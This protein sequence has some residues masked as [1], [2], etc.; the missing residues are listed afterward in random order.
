M[1]Q[2]WPQDCKL[3]CERFSEFVTLGWYWPTSLDYGILLRVYYPQLL[4]SRPNR[5]MGLYWRLE[6][7]GYHKYSF[8][9]LNILSE[10]LLNF[11]C[12]LLREF[13]LSFK[14][15]SDPDF[16]RCTLWTLPPVSTSPG[17]WSSPCSKK[18]PLPRL[19]LA[20]TASTMICG[21]TLTRAKLNK[22]SEVL[23]PISIRTTG[24]NR[25]RWKFLI[26]Y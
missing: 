1:L 4:T 26:K 2:D 9:G 8:C 20:R 18:P 10:H 5:K 13:W 12:R 3:I 19:T 11:L 15:I 6:R 16:T 24:N 14:T 21:S 23:P 17:K 7:N 22:D 25:S